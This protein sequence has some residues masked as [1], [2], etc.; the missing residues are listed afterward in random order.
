MPRWLTVLLISL[1]LIAVL[2][3]FM[4][5]R[6]S[7]SG[8]QG[9]VRYVG[10]VPTAFTSPFHVAI[11]EGAKALATKKGWKIAV[12]APA[13]EGDFA[14]H[15]TIVQQIIQ[16]GV[17]AISVNPMNVDAMTSGVKAA[18]IAKIPLFMHNFITPL[19]DTSI[20]VTS[21]IGYDQ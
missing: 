9:K 13:S 18:N 19:A 2:V 15:V 5:S 12:Q 1:L 8:S 17:D 14:A 4:A 21:Y 16:T 10:F 7:A 3:G 11:A 20:Q 6:P